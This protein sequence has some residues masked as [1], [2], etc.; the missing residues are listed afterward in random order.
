[1][2]KWIYK[3]IFTIAIVPLSLFMLP[4]KEVKA[5]EE[6]FAPILIKATWEWSSLEQEKSYRYEYIVKYKI[7]DIIINY[8]NRFK[9]LLVI[10]G[11]SNIIVDSM[12]LEE[13]Q[14]E[15][16]STAFYVRIT[17][18]ST[19][20][21]HYYGSVENFLNKFFVDDSAFYVYYDVYSEGYNEGHYDGYDEG[22]F[23]GKQEGYDFGYRVGWNEGRSDLLKSVFIAIGVIIAVSIVFGIIAFI[24]GRK[25]KKGR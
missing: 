12:T 19:L 22:Y 10:Q 17:M 8:L 13:I 11:V 21:N 3:L 23:I 9:Y 14:V 5:L 16:N 25:I 6:D 1:M 7:D 2:K 20:I 4:K 18:S 24:L 15:D